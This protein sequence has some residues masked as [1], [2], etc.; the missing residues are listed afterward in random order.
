MRQFHIRPDF[1]FIIQKPQKTQGHLAR[2]QAELT[3]GTCSPVS[4]RPQRSLLPPPGTEVQCE[5]PFIVTFA[6]VFPLYSGN[7]SKRKKRVPRLFSIP[8]L[9]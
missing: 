2:S 3:R 1:Q 5:L 9:T 4:H 6:L 7:V 8:P